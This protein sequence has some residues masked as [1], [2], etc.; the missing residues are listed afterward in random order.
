MTT[1][2]R[3]GR[4]RGSAG[5]RRQAG[6]YQ[7]LA[8][9]DSLLEAQQQCLADILALD[10]AG[11]QSGPALAQALSQALNGFLAAAPA[12]PATEREQRAQ[13]IQAFRLRYGLD[14]GTP[15]TLRQVGNTTQSSAEGARLR[16][17][18]VRDYLRLPALAATWVPFLRSPGPA[19]PEPG[20]P[21]GL[22]PLVAGPAIPR[23]VLAPATP[24]AV[25][26]LIPI[27]SCL[28]CGWDMLTAACGQVGRCP[29]CQAAYLLGTI[30]PPVPLDMHGLLAA[31]LGLS[32]PA[33][34]WLLPAGAD[35]RG[36][37]ITFMDGQDEVR[38]AYALEMMVDLAARPP[39][40]VAVAL[41]S[42]LRRGAVYIIGPTYAQAGHGAGTI[43]EVVPAEPAT[44]APT[45]AQIL[46]H[47]K[48]PLRG[49]MEVVQFRAALVEAMCRQ[50]TAGAP[51]AGTAPSAKT[52]DPTVAFAQVVNI[53]AEHTGWL[54]TMLRPVTGDSP[55]PLR[56]A[57]DLLA[58]AA[59]S[60]C[61]AAAGRSAWAV[62]QAVNTVLTALLASAW[63]D[64][65]P[66]VPPSFWDT[67]WGWVIAQARQYALASGDLITISAA[68]QY[69]GVK[70]QTVAAAIAQ[71]ALAVVVDHLAPARRGR[72]LLRREDVTQRW[73]AAQA[74]TGS[75]GPEESDG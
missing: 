31:A 61:D 22:L 58:L 60:G 43:G 8:P 4:P 42:D 72:R 27:G 62:L 71:G 46:P 44:P 16:I 17:Q 12:T 18:R 68:A 1:R 69:A 67:P 37:T 2:R 52:T 49:S 30:W 34:P 75:T 54:Q 40:E 74:S 23:Y 53:V 24:P 32:L 39:A 7:T 35:M 10:P 36:S 70:V 19:A 63:Q 38:G 20:Q 26:R 51:A 25:P 55:A 29:R 9:Q 57:V 15:A 33:E 41:Q 47:V 14:T 5:H 50:Q 6:A 56:Q 59:Q 3:S 13:A 66:P 11:I 64:T 28:Y 21:P 48:Q 73:P 45:W 65:M